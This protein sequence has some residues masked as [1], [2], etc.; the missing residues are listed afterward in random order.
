MVVPTAPAPARY[1]WRPY[2]GC[3]YLYWG[4]RQ[5]GGY[6]PAENLYRTFDADRGQWG[7]ATP[8]PW[9]PRGTTRPMAARK[10]ADICNDCKEPACTCPGG[11]PCLR[12][13]ACKPDCPCGRSVEYSA[14]GEEIQNFGLIRNELA[15][16]KDR[17]YIRG[18][19]VPRRE[20]METV[21]AANLSDDSQAVR[22]TVIGPKEL[23]QPVLE[24][25]AKTPECQGVAIKAYDPTHWVV[26]KAGF[27][28]DGQPS[29][30]VQRPDGGVVARFDQQPTQPILAQAVLQAKRQADP[31]YDPK[32]DPQGP[33]APPSW[34]DLLQSPW[35]PV[36]GLG[37]GGLLLLLLK[38]KG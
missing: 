30:Y 12:G 26:T 18:E 11:G 15:G 38:K 32:K 21:R 36:A 7:P 22:V 3:Y 17:Y 10:L 14:Q 5:V 16:G 19:R 24:L 6:D 33:S 4:P 27:K 23:R 31:N 37:A 8:P 20:F 1:E 9:E 28:A 35:G 29:V 2:G 13:A 34:Q 25:L